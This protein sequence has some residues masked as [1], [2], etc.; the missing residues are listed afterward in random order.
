MDRSVVV[1]STVAVILYLNTLTADFAY[2][3]SRAI[4]KNQD[5]LPDTPI[6]NVFY[7]DFWGTPLTHSGSHKSYRPLCVLSFRLNYYLHGLNPMGYHL[8][9]IIL[10]ALVTGLFTHLA[11]IVLRR[12]LAAL[13][14][15]LLFAAHP[16]HTEAVAGIVGRADVGCCLFFL[17]SLL[18]YMKYCKFRDKDRPF[19]QRW[20]FLVGTAIFTAASLLTKEQGVT[21]LAVCAIYDIFIQ[22][23]IPPK[24]IYYI[25]TKKKY[26]GLLEGLS[27]L[28]LC[29]IS[30]VAFRLY[31]MEKTPPEFAP[32]DNPASDSDSYVTRTLTY[33]LLPTFNFWLCVCPRVLSFDWSMEAI[34]LVERF[35]D[36][37]N[38][39]TVIFYSAVGYFAFFILKSFHVKGEGSKDSFNGNGF[40]HHIGGSHTYHKPHISHKSRKH[41]RRNSSSSTDSNEDDSHSVQEVS[42]RTIEVMILSI[43]LIVFPFIPATNLFFYV[44]FVIAERV[45]YIPSLGFCLLV[46]HGAHIL[47]KHCQ[48]KKHFGQSVVACCAVLVAMFSMK[49][50]VRNM[51]WESEENLYRSGISI[52]PPKAWGNL[53]NIFNSRGMVKEAEESY[54]A[55][56]T[57][58]GNMADVHYNLGILL[59]EQKRYQEAI[60]SYTLAINFRPRLTM[61]HLNLGIVFG[62]L[63]KNAEAE[64]AYTHCSNID[65]SGLKDPRLH[66]STK[67]SALFNLGR[68]LS[69]QER[70]AEAVQ[71][72]QQAIR[73]RP[74]HYAPQSLYNMLGEAYMK[75]QN[76]EEAE[77]WY[78]EALKAKPEHVPAH[79]TMAKLMQKRGRLADAEE[80][81]KKAQKLDP[82]DSSVFQHYAQYLADVGRTKEAAEM[83][84]QALR[85]T[86]E[87]FELVFN[88]A[89]SLRQAG[90]NLD[91]E[92][93][94]KR[95][96]DLKPD[97]ATA[98]MNLGAMYHYNNKLEE[99]EKSYLR[100]LNLKPDDT[101]TQENLKKL[102]NLMRT[103]GK[104]EGSR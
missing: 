90:Q 20:A 9:N 63:G 67:I 101:L 27:W 14:A 35:T 41:L 68:L 95:A 34:P 74:P 76:M 33:F 70:P 91:A 75:L 102:R 82:K 86:P 16:V 77:F 7:D 30:M 11:G 1:T 62:I 12:K 103:K 98:H 19:A 2:D 73:R 71:V 85:L 97:M 47:Y 89:N 43:A 53:A 54:R 58:R 45:L 93:Y 56:L 37:R 49:T 100:A 23:K 18:S 64:K 5:L 8:G 48:R 29:G 42:S 24:Y 52:N 39:F 15:G 88:T 57:Y 3:D 83:N 84:L 72:Y 32:A 50:V 36:P 65:I 69:D 104:R 51:D 40:A 79:L 17:L 10:H 13:F 4:K 28:V 26:R 78:K 25:F 38:M 59:Q 55:A 66:E 46:S 44:G 61:A 22:N 94:Y 87:D 31:F 92:K 96:A 81:F 80:W 21:V 6:I 99:A 60:E